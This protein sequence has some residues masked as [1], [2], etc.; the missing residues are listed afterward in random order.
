MALADE[1][2]AVGVN[3]RSDEAGANATVAAI[4]AAG[5]RAVALHGDVANGTGDEIGRAS[6][7]ERV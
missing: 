3:Y 1:G 4:E 2:A 5:G 7:R 6:C